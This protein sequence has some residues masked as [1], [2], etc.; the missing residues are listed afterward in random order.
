MATNP[1]TESTVAPK[2][3]ANWLIPS[4]ESTGITSVALTAIGYLWYPVGLAIDT[5]VNVAFW[6]ARTISNLVS[7]EPT[8]EDKIDDVD[9]GAYDYVKCPVCKSRLCSKP[10][11]A[12]VHLLQLSGGCANKMDHLLITC[13]KCK[14][15]YLFTLAD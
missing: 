2:T 12:W 1:T 5:V 13:H 11:G 4:D 9:E 14:S 10:K 7:T 3:W 15:K 6:C 8:S